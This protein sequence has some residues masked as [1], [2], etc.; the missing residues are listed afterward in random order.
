MTHS[1]SPD[2]FTVALESG[3]SVSAMH[4]GAAAPVSGG[5]FIVAHGAGA[6]QHHPFMTAFAHAVAASG[7][8]TVTFDFP[9]TEQRRKLPDRAPALEA[10]YAAVIRD[11]RR[12]LASA[13]RWLFI[14]GK[15]MGGRVATRVADALGA[16]R[17]V[18]FGYPFHPPGKPDLPQPN[19]RTTHLETLRTPTLIFQ[20]T[21]DPFGGRAEVESYPLS[22]AIR[23]H[24]IED[25]DHDLRCRK[26]VVGRT[27]ADALDEACEAAAAFLL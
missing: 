8:D 14:G 17:V 16:H 12:R 1:N 26:A 7:F 25:G 20:G 24:W 15:S 2:A 9:Y 13:E 19:A 10:C 22:A 5:A 6:G 27:A 18:V 3:A 21:R 23:L 11:T 4:Y